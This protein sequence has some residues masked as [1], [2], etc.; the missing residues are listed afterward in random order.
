LEVWGKGIKDKQGRSINVNEEIK[1]ILELTNTPE[2]DYKKITP[3]TKLTQWKPIY[4]KWFALYTKFFPFKA[5]DRRSMSQAQRPEANEI[6]YFGTDGLPYVTRM[7]FDADDTVDG[8][9]FLRTNRFN[10][11]QV[12]Q[13]FD[14]EGKVVRP[15]RF[16][17]GKQKGSIPLNAKVEKVFGQKEI[18]R[19]DLK[20]VLN[21][22]KAEKAFQKR[23]KADPQ[24]KAWYD[25]KYSRVNVEKV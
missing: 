21:S 4:R 1:K 17:G 25:K 16:E 3:E 5:T 18:G 6:F 22:D 24:L 13:L 23:L 2:H 11:I 7:S 19:K 12:D 14:Q 20:K 10:D 9:I 15:M 8:T